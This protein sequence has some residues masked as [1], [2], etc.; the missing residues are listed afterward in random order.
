MSVCLNAVELLDITARKITASEE[1]HST[2]LKGDVVVKKGKDVL[3]ADEVVIKTDSKRKPQEYKAIGNVRF[4]VA[5]QARVMKGKAK[6]IVYNAQKDEYHLSGGVVVEEVGSPNVLRG[7][8]IVLNSKTGYANVVG[9]DK[10]PARI[11]FSLEDDKK[12]GK[13]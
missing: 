13:K 9:G 11:I 8:E 6:V 10:R 5:L 3:Y 12:K 1:K 2:I 7:E 4:K